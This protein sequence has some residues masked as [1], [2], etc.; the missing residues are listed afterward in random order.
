VGGGKWTFLECFRR[1][2]EEDD[3]FAWTELVEVHGV[4]SAVSSRRLLQMARAYGLEHVLEGFT[5]DLLKRLR[6]TSRKNDDTLRFIYKLVVEKV[7][8]GDLAPNDEEAQAGLVRARLLYYARREL[9]GAVKRIKSKQERA[10]CPELLQP[11][12][13]E[14]VGGDVLDPTSHDPALKW[15]KEPRKR[16]EKDLVVAMLARQ[17]PEARPPLEIMLYPLVSVSPE[18]VGFIREKHAQ[19]LPLG[20]QKITA[21]S[22]SALLDRV[23]RNRTGRLPSRLVAELCGISVAAVDQR[24]KRFTDGLKEALKQHDF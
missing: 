19:T 22:L 2:I 14:S 10:V 16:R 8:T 18:T 11:V 12:D 5:E 15:E 3:Q 23:E 24:F 6:S 21:K 9:K 13:L 4:F 7:E 17:K 1:A 20:L